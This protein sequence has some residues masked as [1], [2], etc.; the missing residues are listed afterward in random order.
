VLGT[1]TILSHTLFTA[2]V[3]GT[4]G[5]PVLHTLPCGVFPQTTRPIASTTIPQAFIDKMPR[6]DVPFDLSPEGDKW[7][8]HA[9]MRRQDIG[10][11]RPDFVPDEPGQTIPHSAGN[12]AIRDHEGDGHPGATI[13]LNAPIFGQIDIYMVQTAHTEISASWDGGDFIQG[14]AHVIEFGHRSI[15]ASNRLFTANPDVEIDATQSRWRLTRVPTDTTCAALKSG[16]GQGTPLGPKDVR[17][18]D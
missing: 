18:R 3:D 7:R 2:M 14:P 8:L 6:K 12:A 10:W 13:Y 5:A 17:P 4:P 11:H 9:D 1:T 16:V 15:G